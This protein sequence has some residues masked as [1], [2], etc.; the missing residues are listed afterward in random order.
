MFSNLQTRERKMDGTSSLRGAMAYRSSRA[1]VDGFQ[2][3]YATDH[4]NQRREIVERFQ[5]FLSPSLGNRQRGGDR[6]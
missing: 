4:E 5:E 2:K 6:R 3:A 1:S